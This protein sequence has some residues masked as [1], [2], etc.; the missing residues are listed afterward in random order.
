MR[1]WDG[2]EI[3]LS[4]REWAVLD[5]LIARNAPSCRKARGSRKRFAAFGAGGREQHVVSKS[6]SPASR[7][8]L[9]KDA[10]ETVRGVGYRISADAN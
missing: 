2:A 10:I 4:S 8:K 1:L 3:L 9:G 6:M 7:R 5:R